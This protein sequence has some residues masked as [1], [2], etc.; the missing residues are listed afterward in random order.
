ML[1][2]NGTALAVEHRHQTGMTVRYFREVESERPIPFHARI[3]YADED[4][5]VVDKPHFLPVMP[6]GRFVRETVLRRLMIELGNPDLVPL[7][8]IDRGTA[9][10]VLFSA[11]PASRGLYQSLFRAR[12][13]EK[14]YEALAPALPEVVFPLAH[15]SRIVRGEPFFRMREDDGPE[16]SE[17]MIN[18]IGKAG[19]NWRYALRPITGRKHQLRVHMAALGAG[20]LNDR[21]YPELRPEA[22]DEFDK[23]LKLLARRLSFTDPISGRRHH[24][25]SRLT[26]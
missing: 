26:L 7:H 1:D 25:E 23:P 10:L 3:V 9:G 22:A 17:S 15:R 4:L 12:A 20:I 19:S 18:L 16:N 5:V 11:R 2:A 8:R 21:L 14:H 13:V 6:A 24:F